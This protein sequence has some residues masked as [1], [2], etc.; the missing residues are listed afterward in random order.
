MSGVSNLDEY[1]EIANDILSHHKK[2]D[3]TGYPRGLKGD[4]IPIRARIIALADAFDAMV[5]R[6]PYRE[7]LSI[8]EAKNEI[9][10]CSGTQFDRKLVKIFLEIL[11]KN[12][13][14]L[15]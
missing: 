12:P 1:A 14:V 2:Y 3:G 5:S 11:D 6:R 13:Q 15:Q 4:N 7:P 9:L 8:K 10:R